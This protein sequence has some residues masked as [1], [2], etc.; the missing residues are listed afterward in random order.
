MGR[1]ISL[2][3]EPKTIYQFKHG[4]NPNTP[5]AL[6]SSVLIVFFSTGFFNAQREDLVLQLQGTF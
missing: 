6:Q 3:N 5:W 4:E 2:L 1:Y